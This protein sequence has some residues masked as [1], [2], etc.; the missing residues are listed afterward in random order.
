M[1]VLLTISSFKMEIVN[2]KTGLDEMCSCKLTHNGAV[3]IDV[4][5]T[6]VGTP[7]D[8]F[9]GLGDDQNKFTFNQS[10][11]TNGTL[12]SYNLNFEQHA[13]VSP[14]EE[15]G[16][17]LMG[18]DIVN[19]AQKATFSLK[20]NQLSVKGYTDVFPSATL[21]VNGALIFQYNQPSFVKTHSK[22]KRPQPSFYERTQTK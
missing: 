18:Y 3:H 13:S 20:N 15:F 9:P 4:G 14:S 7:R 5:T 21:S 1:K 8:Y 22:G 10:K 6:P 16:L 11:N 17:G 12:N 19:V 2:W